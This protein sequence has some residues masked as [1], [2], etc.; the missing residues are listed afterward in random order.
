[1]IGIGS[2]WLAVLLSAVFVFIASSFVHIA[3]K[4]HWKDWGDIPSEDAIAEA[5]R[6]AGVA[7]GNYRIPQCASMAEA[8]SEA[9]IEKMNKGPV[10]LISVLPSGPPRMGK[11]LRQWFV[12]TLVVG[13]IV[14]YVSGR[15]LTAGAEYL[16]VFRIAGT[17]AFLAHFGAEP[18]AS[19][20][21][22]QSWSTT[23]KFFFDSL[24][25]SLLTAGTFAWLWPA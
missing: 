7:P 2:L 6:K 11:S 14:A 1:M 24:I 15:T 10:A 16:S 19:I 22:G 21:K 13:V 18:L 5:F 20:W 9:M 17:T 12:Y 3:L 25:Y 8:G 4:Y 23:G